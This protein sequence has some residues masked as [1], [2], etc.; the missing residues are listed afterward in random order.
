VHTTLGSHNP[1]FAAGSEQ[2]AATTS[3]APD[4]FRS[5]QIKPGTGLG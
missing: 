3:P 2:V 4:E 5:S 1:R